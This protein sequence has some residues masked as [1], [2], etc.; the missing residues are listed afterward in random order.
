[1]VRIRVSSGL[2]KKQRFFSWLAQDLW[3]RLFCYLSDLLLTES[4]FYLHKMTN[5]F[6]CYFDR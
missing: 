6:A 5:D 3:A 1:M 2:T 4:I